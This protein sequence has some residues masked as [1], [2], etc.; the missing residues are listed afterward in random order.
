MQSLFG[1]H[2]TLEVVTNGIFVL[3]AN[4]TDAQ[5][6]SHKDAKK[7]DCQTLFCIQSAVDSVNFD[8]I[9]HVESANEA[10]DILVKYYEG[11]EKVKGVN[12]KALRRQYELLQMGEDEKIAGYVAKVQNI[13]H[14][15]KDCGETIT[16]KMIVEKIMCMLTYQFDHVIVAIQESN[17]LETLKLEDLT[18]SLEAHELR[19]VERKGVQD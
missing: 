6:V 9:S 4:A 5:R 1:F 10:W 3:A 18:G 14:L 17:N 19:I 16:D 13:V 8:Q 7:K 12:V 15:M 2:E 11:D